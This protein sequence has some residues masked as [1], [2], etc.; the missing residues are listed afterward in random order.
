M[1]KKCFVIMPF[2]KTES[3]TEDEW[4][5]FFQVFLK[6][7]IQAMGYEC[8]RS[9][10]SPSNIIQDIIDQIHTSDLVV[11]VLT[12]FNPNVLYELGVRHSLKRGTIMIMEEGSKIPS[13]FSNFGV[14]PYKNKLV[15]GEKFKEDLKFYIDKIEQSLSP[16]NPVGEYLA[17]NTASL[18]NPAAE[19]LSHLFDKITW[20]RV[21]LQ[22]LA[23]FETPMFEFE[24][25]C[26]AGGKFLDVSGASKK[27][28]IIVHLYHY[29]GGPN[30]K[31][32][33]HYKSGAYLIKSK[34]SGKAIELID[35]TTDNGVG[36]CQ[37][38]LNGQTTQLW[39]IDT[40]DM[41]QTYS[42][43]SAYSK[44]RLDA[45]LGDVGVDCCKVQQWDYTKG[46]NQKWRININPIRIDGK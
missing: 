28:K 10:A 29:H 41:G 14:I 27:D 21:S 20:N 2:S 13:D 17:K 7:S 8:E 45:D 15:A 24:I 38:M 33:I 12:D 26:C 6:P 46:I 4:T 39:H 42:I 25:S 11:A 22:E 44:L 9:K 3:Q 23:S 32:H 37:N 40:E 1:N 43:V 30:Q 31:W 16:D 19:K 36:I 35:P 34:N 18:E 5:D